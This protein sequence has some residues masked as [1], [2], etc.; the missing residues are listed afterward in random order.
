M[1]KTK[2]NIKPRD[3]FYGKLYFSFKLVKC[4]PIVDANACVEM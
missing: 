1:Q 3:Y 4:F 2:D